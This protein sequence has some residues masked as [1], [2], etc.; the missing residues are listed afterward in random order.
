MSKWICTDQDTN[1]YRCQRSSVV[2][3]FKEDRIINPETGETE[4]YE[5]VIDLDDH[6][7]IEIAEALNTFG[8]VYHGDYIV[9]GFDVEESI[10]LIAECLFELSND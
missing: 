4:V 10:E 2:F 3:E 5:N 7:E 1:Q 8:H 9:E 6:A